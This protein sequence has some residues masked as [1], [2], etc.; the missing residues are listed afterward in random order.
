MKHLYSFCLF[1]LCSLSAFQAV[2]APGD[3]TAVQTHVRTKLSNN[4]N[5]DTTVVFPANLPASRKI[6]M[7]FT[8]G[9]YTC[10][11][12]SQYCA[13]WD[14][15][16]MIYLEKPSG[17]SLEIG[18][19]ITPYA[20]IS[21]YPVT[22][23]KPYVFDVTDY[24]ALLKNNS[25]IRIKYSGYS[26]GFT[27]NIKFD[28]IEG[29]PPR[30]VVGIQRVWNGYF[31]YGNPN[32][33]I[34]ASVDNRTYQMPANAQSAVLKL[35]L[36]GHGGNA[37]DNCAEFCQK[38][39]LIK[40]NN[41]Q[42]SQ[43]TIWRDNCG[44]NN[45][46]PQTGTWLYDRANWCPGDLVTP[47]V[48]NLNGI[49][50]G[51][52]YSVD[53][54]FQNYINNTTQAGWQLEGQIIYYGA[55]NNPTDAS[56]EHI[57]SP[58]NDMAFFRDNQVC[59]EPKI[60][61]K[62]TGSTTLTSL[63]IQYGLL[64]GTMHTYTWQGSLAVGQTTRI[65]LPTVPEIQNVT[66]SNVKFIS[67][68]TKAN[69]TPDAYA[70]NNELKSTFTP[71]PSLP[72]NL[73]IT[74][75]TNNARFN[76]FNETTWKLYDAYG[77]LI[78]Q[79]I[80]NPNSSSLIDT[81]ALQQGCYRL[82]VEDA[83]CDGVQWWAYQYYQPNPGNGSISLKEKGRPQTLAMRGYYAGD[84]GCGFNYLFY[85]ASPLGIKKETAP[86]EL[87]VFPNPA[88][89]L[90]QVNI[91]DPKAHSGQLKLVNALGQVVFQTKAATG[92]IQVPVKN[93]A[94]GVYMLTYQAGEFSV[95]KQVIVAH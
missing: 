43:Q 92:Q 45:L 55:Y 91:T 76:G 9:K 17:E 31:T 58:S 90:L 20:G 56:M 61:V 11:A 1:L 30:N 25:T 36:T 89:D 28:F 38:Y 15:T 81:F 39:Y 88:S 74:M 66:G 19:M 63:E 48:H 53:M 83:G 18:R 40:L 33:P 64:N 79:R 8:L 23:K 12:G 77:T 62:N 4:G 35:S 46:Y 10:P 52:N 78:K 54:D 16:V 29:T 34:E 94:A 57:V 51:A 42:I 68:I 37:N 5:Y 49:T 50:P 71:L 27:A 95:H 72:N 13:D 67:R 6:N 82:A 85:V 21:Q 3:T 41:T 44:L 60:E 69:G 59:E 32:T 75:N 84:F 86:F 24:A 80:N 22:W 26:G 2:A 7:T 87:N 47:Y 93:I 65:A 70:L 73:V 14:Y